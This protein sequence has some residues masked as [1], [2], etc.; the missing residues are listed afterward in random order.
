MTCELRLASHAKGVRRSD[1]RSGGHPQRRGGG[2]SPSPNPLTSGALRLASRLRLA[3]TAKNV[4]RSDARSGMHPQHREG[5]PPS[6][7]RSPSAHLRRA[8][9][10]QRGENE[11]HPLS[12]SDD[13]GRPACRE[14]Q[15]ISRAS[16]STNLAFFHARDAMS[17]SPKPNSIP[18]ARAR[19]VDRRSGPP[20]GASK[21]ALRAAP[22]VEHHGATC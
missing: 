4:R 3:A 17:P 9:L 18:A 7:L 6:A 21:T 20:R 1:A 10:R 5:G 19:S 13:N 15:G 8:R 11:L 12:P 2:P 16:E 22:E 14:T